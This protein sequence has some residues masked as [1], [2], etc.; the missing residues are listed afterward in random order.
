MLNGFRIIEFEGIGPG[1]FAAMML[2]DLG[3][4]VIVIQRP[5]SANPTVGDHNL[6]DRGKRTIILDL[7]D[8]ADLAVAMALIKSS[9]ALIEGNRPGVMERLGLGPDTCHKAHTKL[10]YA[11]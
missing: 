6:L 2:A 3:A 5:N 9:D 11:A 7:K 8:S 4:E 10:V 1:P